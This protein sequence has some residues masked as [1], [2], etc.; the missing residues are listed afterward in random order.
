[1]KNIKLI[2]TL[3]AVILLVPSC[4]NDGGDSVIETKN[5]TAPNIQ[6]TV[7]SEQAINFININNGGDVNLEFT[8]DIG[9]GQENFE[10]LDVVLFYI[11]GDGTI[12]KFI[13]DSGVSSLPKTY[14]LTLEDIFAAFPDVNAVSDITIQDQLIVSTDITLTDGTVI[15]MTNDDGSA[16]YA[17]NIANSPYYSVIQ[18][19]DV[20]CP[21]DDASNFSGNYKVVSDAWADYEPGG[22]I[23]LEYH[24]E[25]DGQYTFRVM[26]TNNPYIAN[27]DTSYLLVTI[28]PATAKI[29]GVSNEAF[30]YGPNDQYPVTV[31]GE[32][33][34][35]TG[36][37]TLDLSFMGSA[38]YRL[39]IEKE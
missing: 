1:M 12:N 33:K 4:E 15:K 21:I 26:S 11:K 24:P 22:D 25:E 13:L 7:D 29:T 30:I 38:P 8:V 28:D 34:S 5:G 19:Y 18:T 36:A 32:V 9:L 39:I 31:T 17:P 10:S 37:V 27:P 35:C 20:S 3:L 6:K 14:S 2:F 16:N 23:P